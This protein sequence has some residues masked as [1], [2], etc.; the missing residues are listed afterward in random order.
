LK[1]EQ[2]MQANTF[3]SDRRYRLAF[4]LTFMTGFA[5]CTRGIAHT[6]EYGWLHPSSVSGIT[7]GVAA[8]SLAG[9]VL[10]RRRI[11]P[12]ASEKSA[13]ITLVGI[14]AVKFILS[15]LYPILR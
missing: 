7:L 10:M 12:I 13:L 1:K 2:N 5:L 3:Q 9:V 11:G 8:I 14:M 6:T 15:A 4:G